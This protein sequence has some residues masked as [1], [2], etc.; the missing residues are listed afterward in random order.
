MNDR[1]WTL[2]N[3]LS[4]LRILLVVPVAFLLLS[5][6]PDSRL[7][8]ALLIAVAVLTDFLDGLIA[9]MNNEVTN[10]GKII[11]PIADK[12]GI[13]ALAVILTVQGTLPP[14]F[15][16]AVVGRDLVILA[17]AAHLRRRS[18]ATPQSN[19]TGKWTAGFLGLTL[20]VAVVDPA[21]SAGILR[22][23]LAASAA[24][25]ALSSVSY[26]RRFFSPTIH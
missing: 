20:F 22:P 10:F 19:R 16:I 21:D 8:A 1:I 4:L 13:G 3:G 15:T 11:D 14:W 7:Y 24:M 2:S 9:R 18:A 23:F 17:A 5:G 25:I 6:N 26:A 12:V